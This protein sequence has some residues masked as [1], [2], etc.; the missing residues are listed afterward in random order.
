MR[1]QTR[2]IAVF[3]S[4]LY[5]RLL[6][7]F[8]LLLCSRFALWAQPSNLL[9]A[10]FK[11][12]W[13]STENGS[14]KFWYA[15][16]I[17]QTEKG[18]FLLKSNLPLDSQEDQVGLRSRKNAL[19][20]YD[21]ALTWKW[22]KQINTGNKNGHLD[23]V[24]VMGNNV[25]ALYSGSSED[26]NT[27]SL[28]ME[29]IDLPPGNASPANTL[30]ELP[31]NKAA[32]ALPGLS[33]LSPNHQLLALALRGNGASLASIEQ[34]TLM[35]GLCGADLQMKTRKELAVPADLIEDPSAKLFLSNDSVIFIV[36]QIRS[37]Q[38]NGFRI[39]RY[40][41][42][43]EEAK[44]TFVEL[45]D[46]Q[47]VGAQ[48]ALDPV[49]SNLVIA[50]LYSNLS[51]QSAAGFFY[52]RINTG[53]LSLSVNVSHPY[54]DDFLNQFIG[55]PKS[56]DKKELLN[57]TLA[58][59]VLRQD[60]GV[61][62][63]AE[64]RFQS[65]YAYY[66]FFT[67]T[68]VTRTVSHFDN[69]TTMSLSA[70]GTAEWAKNIDKKQ[71]SQ[72]DDGYYLSYAPIVTNQQIQLLFNKPD[73]KFNSILLYSI[74]STGEISTSLFADYSDNATLIPKGSRQVAISAALFPV[75]RKNRFYLVRANF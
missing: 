5:R 30:L 54:S 36:G 11:T 10:T 55:E 53:N 6:F 28:R 9:K 23:S 16:V 48:C 72:E 70:D 44:S 60:G 47:I 65:E 37:G 43:N 13:S 18:S 42:R 73:D 26:G 45:V 51:S 19:V 38:T 12:E 67:K 35:V 69:I 63:L 2:L 62:I 24:F 46:R 75:F 58:N 74:S 68:Y 7:F 20:F 31:R 39:Y 17:G 52:T 21:P 57:Y 8:V 33:S 15:R 56:S 71:D 66:D 27:F 1:A 34:H 49:N 25:L 40:D 64:C 41:F 61:V 50:G 3:K 22:E 32:T 59:L 14:A 29:R 4:V